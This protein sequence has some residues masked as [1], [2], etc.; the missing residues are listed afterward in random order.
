[1]TCAII[2]DQHQSG[3]YEIYLFFFPL[4]SFF[5]RVQQAQKKESK[6]KRGRNRNRN[7]SAV[8]RLA[9][10]RAIIVVVTT[11]LFASQSGKTEKMHECSDSL[12]LLPLRR[13][14][15]DHS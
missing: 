10:V 7:P 8:V 14:L 1:M 6:T 15:V 2:N 13:T 5:S 11:D 4:L 12:L 3:V 9:R